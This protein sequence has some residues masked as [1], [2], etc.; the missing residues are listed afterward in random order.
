MYDGNNYRLTNYLKGS[1]VSV[2]VVNLR[3]S[4]GDKVVLKDVS[5]DVES[6]QTLVILG[7]S[8]AGKSVFLKHIVGLLSADSGLI[9]FN[10]EIIDSDHILDSYRIAFVFQSSAL[11]NSM[12]VSSS[13]SPPSP[14]S[15]PSTLSPLSAPL[16]LPGVNEVINFSQVD[17][18]K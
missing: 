13:N 7:K 4:F 6:G 17:P 8:G 15:S 2:K 5:L 12:T 14:I 16:I 1:P 11:F 18:L 9:Y 10:D 3:K